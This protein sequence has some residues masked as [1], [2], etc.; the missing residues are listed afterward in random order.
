MRFLVGGL[1]VS[2][3][4]DD[5][6]SVGVGAGGGVELSGPVSEF[7]QLTPSSL[8]LVDLV[9]EI[10]EVFDE[11]SLGVLTAAGAGVFEVQHSV[12]LRQRE[13]GALGLSD[14]S[15]PFEGLAA[16]VPVP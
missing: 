15:E 6:A 10:S 11:Q 2:A 13:A 1:G 16:V 4:V 8:E 3:G 9:V 12:D 14:E 7:G 5:L